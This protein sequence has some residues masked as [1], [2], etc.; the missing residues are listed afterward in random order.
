MTGIAASPFAGYL[1]RVPRKQAGVSLI[2]SIQSSL[3]LLEVKF[4][5]RVPVPDA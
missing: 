2:Q 5:S 3:A 1:E 4:S